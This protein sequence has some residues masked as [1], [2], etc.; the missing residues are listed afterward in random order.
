MM[1]C[2]WCVC[3]MK[4]W[5]DSMRIINWTNVK[6]VTRRLS[7]KR[8]LWNSE[9]DIVNTDYMLNEWEKEENNGEL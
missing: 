6:V 3:F 1:C 5:K 2:H 9:T 8:N 4:M 7:L